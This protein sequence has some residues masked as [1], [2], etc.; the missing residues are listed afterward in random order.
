MSESEARTANLFSESS[1]RRCSIASFAKTRRLSCS[2]QISFCA[3]GTSYSMAEP[4]FGLDL[5][6]TSF[7]LPLTVRV[8]TFQ[9]GSISTSNS[10]TMV[11]ITGFSSAYWFYS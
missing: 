6:P 2:Y 1:L 9:R 7:A 8:R 4:D 10:A 11:S 3:S 5:R